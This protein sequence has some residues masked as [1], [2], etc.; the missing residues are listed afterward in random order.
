MNEHNFSEIYELGGSLLQHYFEQRIQTTNVGNNDDNE[1]NAHI[2]AYALYL[3]S[4]NDADFI[5]MYDNIESN[6]YAPQEG[7]IVVEN[8][9]GTYAYAYAYTY[10]FNIDLMYRCLAISP[11]P[12]INSFRIIM[13][14]YK[15]ISLDI[16]RC[17]LLHD[18]G[19]NYSSLLTCAGDYNVYKFL[20]NNMSIMEIADYIS[21]GKHKLLHLYFILLI[22]KI[23]DIHDKYLDDI[24][25]NLLASNY[26]FFDTYLLITL[27]CYYIIKC[28]INANSFIAHINEL[29]TNKKNQRV[30]TE[31]HLT[32]SDLLEFYLRPRGAH[33][34]CAVN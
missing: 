23:N 7:T 10:V 4:L 8:E 5:N 11:I 27:R 30:F 21:A 2:A 19:I 3:L 14:R 15:Y 31:S 17:K 26:A 20:I 34:K 24:L 32:F 1:R 28:K 29:L 22:D 18:Y 13:E 16:P 25:Y 9:V 6:D 33:T 12:L